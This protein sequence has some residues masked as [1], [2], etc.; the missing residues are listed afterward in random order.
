MWINLRQAIGN[1]QIVLL[2][3]FLVG[4]GQNSHIV[5]DG[6][7]IESF[8]ETEFTFDDG[9][10]TAGILS[11]NIHERINEIEN[12]IFNL[13]DVGKLDL[14]QALTATVEIGEMREL[15]NKNEAKEVYI[16]KGF[17]K[18]GYDFRKSETYGK[19]S[20][21]TDLSRMEKDG[22]IIVFTEWWQNLAVKLKERGAGL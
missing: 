16:I 5:K 15:L 13:V 21:M 4:C 8:S 3:V 11:F 1:I 20:R 9:F 10:C 17:C 14:E 6:A 7:V 22:F 18:D 2:A 12:A 19:L